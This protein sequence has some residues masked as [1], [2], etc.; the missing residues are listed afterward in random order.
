MTQLLI[1]LELWIEIL[2][3]GVSFDCNYLEFKKDFDSVPK[4]YP[5]N[6][7]FMV[8]EDHSMRGPKISY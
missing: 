7:M 6:W 4:Y 3:N 5:K 2:D 8:L 1:T